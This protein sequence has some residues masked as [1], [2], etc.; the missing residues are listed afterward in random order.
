MF[1]NVGEKIKGMAVFLNILGLLA[2]VIGAIVLWNNQYDFWIGLLVFVLGIL[3]SWF[4]SFI[5]YGFGELITKVTK[6]EKGVRKTQMLMIE[7]NANRDDDYYN[8]KIQQMH[9]EIINEFENDFEDDIPADYER[10]VAN[11]NECPFCFGKIS[12]DD[13]ECPHCGNRLK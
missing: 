4:V 3:T 9:D 7:R 8:E 1:K 12:E 5:L 2:A 13:V 11:E 10:D 6:I